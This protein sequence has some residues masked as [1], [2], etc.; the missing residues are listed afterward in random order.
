MAKDPEHRYPSPRALLFELRRAMQ[1]RAAVAEVGVQAL[2]VLVQG[3]V[4]DP[5]DG[6]DAGDQGDDELAQIDLMEALDHAIEFLRQHGFEI[7]MQTSDLVLGVMTV[8]ESYAET[9]LVVLHAAKLLHKELARRE[10]AH[11]RVH[12]NLCVHRGRANLRER[13]VVH[14][15]NRIRGGALLDVGD[16]APRS[17]LHGV[18]A[19]REVMPGRRAE[20]GSRYVRVDRDAI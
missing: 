4:G 2:A 12:I 20:G 14:E 9:R 7:A 11:P 18:Y 15:L 8:L 1:P 17:R 16:W 13:H 5:G 10:S 19:T 6:D 3:S